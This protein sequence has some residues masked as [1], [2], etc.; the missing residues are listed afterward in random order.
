MSKLTKL[1][2]NPK[3]YF[4]DALINIGLLKI[5]K[6]DSPNVFIDYTAILHIGEK[7]SNAL[8]YI[9]LWFDYFVEADILFLILLRDK[10]TYF[11]V[12]EAFPTANIACATTTKEVN[13]L[14]QALPT[15]QVCFYSSNTGNNFSLLRHTHLKHIF[16]GHG[17]SD[18]ASSARKFFRAYDEN[19]V[20]GQAHID[21]IKN[22]NFALNGLKNIK[23]GRPTLTQLMH[24]SSKDWKDRF[25]EAFNLLYLPTWE[26]VYKQQDYSSLEHIVEFS[27]KVLQL[28]NIKVS[29]KLHPHTGKG[30]KKFLK[31][32]QKLEDIDDLNLIPLNNPLS[33]HIV[34]S[35]LFICDISAVVSECLAV[36]SPIFLYIPKD[37]EIVTAKSNMDY[38]EYCY[39]FSSSDELIGLITRVIGGDDYLANGRKMAQD[40]IINTEDTLNQTFVKRLQQEAKVDNV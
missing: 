25:N 15:I 4:K 31:I 29:I 6:P 32:N 39:I 33:Q 9:K 10:D 13:T 18:K 1:L 30:N 34:A 17:D 19:W 26:G 16:I 20:S 36:D 28:E 5:K 40:Y 27:K 24:L 8:S 12:K 35:N 21:R 3:L 23:V 38:S 14:L 37:K 7:G 22:A 11:L 2:H